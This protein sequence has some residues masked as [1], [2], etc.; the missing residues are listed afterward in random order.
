[1]YHGQIVATLD[2]QEATREGLGLLMAGSSAAVEDV[3]VPT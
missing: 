2:A 1:M 3:Q